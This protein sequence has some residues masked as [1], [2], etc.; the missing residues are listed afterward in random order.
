MILAVRIN[1]RCL[2]A[3][4]T[5]VTCLVVILF[6]SS[7]LKNP[8][9]DALVAYSGATMGTTY[10]IKVAGFPEV[11]DREQIKMEI[12]ALLERINRSMSTYIPESEISRFNRLDSISW[13]SVSAIMIKVLTESIRVSTLTNGAFD[14]TIAPLVNLWGFGVKNQ[15]SMVPSDEKINSLKKKTGY[16]KIKVRAAEKLIG[17]RHPDLTI[18]LSAIA[19]GFA[20]DQVGDL[21]ENRGLTNYLVEIGGEI[22]TS[23]FK[24]S[25]KRWIVGIERPTAGERIIQ[26]VI[27]IGDYSMATSGDYR[28]YFEKN[29]KRFSHLID[30]Q[31]GKPINHKLASVSVIHRSCMTADAYATAFMVLG[32]A[33]AYQVALDEKLAAYFLV[34][35]KTGFDMKMTPAFKSFL[36]K[37]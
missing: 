1:K 20:V 21:L 5:W 14:V 16:R 2:A 7:C 34:R 22:R 13:F 23:G 6:L 35:G 17:K 30:P 36:I 25:K 24:G 12:D 28:N 27:A 33:K 32:P 26:Q 37:N 3:K 11:L 8:D 4:V 18:D 9:Q 10:S 29:G 19:K 15:T 31:S